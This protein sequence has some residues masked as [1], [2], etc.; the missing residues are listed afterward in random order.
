MYSQHSNRTQIVPTHHHP[1]GPHDGPLTAE[2]EM[3]NQIRSKLER[4]QRR[5]ARTPSSTCSGYISSSN[6]E[7]HAVPVKSVGIATSRSSQGSNHHSSK[8]LSPQYKSKS[9]FAHVD[10]DPLNGG[11][12]PLATPFLVYS[13]SRILSMES[14]EKHRRC[15]QPRSALRSEVARPPTSRVRFQDL[16]NQNSHSNQ[17]DRKLQDVRQRRYQQV[18]DRELRHMQRATSQLHVTSP[19]T[20]A[21]RHIVAREN[22]PNSAIKPSAYQ[23]VVETLTSS[24]RRNVGTVPPPTSDIKV[25][26]L[27]DVVPRRQN[28]DPKVV[29]QFQNTPE[30]VQLTKTGTSIEEVHEADDT[31]TYDTD[32]SYEFD[33]DAEFLSSSEYAKLVKEKVDETTVSDNDRKQNQAQRNDSTSHLTTKDLALYALGRTSSSSSE[34]VLSSKDKTFNSNVRVSKS[35]LQR[36][37]H[38]SSSISAENY[39]RR[40]RTRAPMDLKHHLPPSIGV[41]SELS[42]GSSTFLLDSTSFYHIQWT[43]GE[44]AFS[45]QQVYPKNEFEFEDESQWFLR[46]LLNTERSTCPNFEHVRV[47]DVLIRVGETDVSDLGLEGSGLVL[48]TFFTKLMAQLPVNL[49]FQRMQSSDWDG[50]VEL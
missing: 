35:S 40:S 36:H 33:S 11:P 28:H 13:T 19:I 3:L 44:F 20:T 4:A 30:T 27:E 12:P 32:D 26:A 10:T 23:K 46:M 16:Q 25:S 38:L 9:K 5:L 29:P 1:H 48:T 6:T 41:L 8:H 14:Q 22:P 49:T 43:K 39:V 24:V 34:V 21:T 37:E 17:K 45:V 50:G 15:E 42:C 2:R 7:K 47:G 31:S 18:Q